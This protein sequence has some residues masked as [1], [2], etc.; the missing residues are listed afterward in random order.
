MNPNSSDPD[1]RQ[2]LDDALNSAENSETLGSSGGSIGVPKE[3]QSSQTQSRQTQSP[4]QKQRSPGMQ[5]PGA[6]ASPGVKPGLEPVEFKPLPLDNGEAPPDIQYS[7][8]Y[9]REAVQNPLKRSGGLMMQL[10][11]ASKK[12]FDT[13]KIGWIVRSPI[14]VDLRPDVEVSERA[15]KDVDDVTPTEQIDP[16]SLT[17]EDDRDLVQP[18]NSR[19]VFTF[20]TRWQVRIPDG[21][22]LIAYSPFNHLHRQQILPTVVAGVDDPS[23][24]FYTI[25]PRIKVEDPIK[26]SRGTP[27]VQLVLVEDIAP[28]VESRF[29]N[30][31]EHAHIQENQQKVAAHYTGDGDDWYARQTDHIM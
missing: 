6:S 18:G 28:A 10:L 13:S 27:L 7:D 23:D 15:D 21:V 5:T 17:Y 16:I 12:A 22:Q 25:K 20:D 26:I 19:N 14:G 8:D 9:L 1:D 4:S 2:S 24:E 29:M 31:P 30:E 11:K 3:P